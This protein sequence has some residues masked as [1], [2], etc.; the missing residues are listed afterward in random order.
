MTS[1]EETLRNWTS[2]VGVVSFGCV[3]GLSL[4]TGME[5]NEDGAVVSRFNITGGSSCVDF[6]ERF[7]VRRRLDCASVGSGSTSGHGILDVPFLFK[8]GIESCTIRNSKIKFK[9]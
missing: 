7:V 2:G 9:Y 3:V 4:L 8:I 5:L 1:L 6:E